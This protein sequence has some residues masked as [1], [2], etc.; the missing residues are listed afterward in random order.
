MAE[1]ES[2]ATTEPV[3]EC[4]CCFEKVNPTDQFCQK[5]GFPVKGTEEE[6]TKF[7]LKRNYQQM[8]MDAHNKKIK[9]AGTSLYVLSGIFLL[10]GLIYFFIRRTDDDAS[11]ILITY[12][13]VAVIFLLPGVWAATKPVASLFQVLYC[14]DCW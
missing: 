3:P 8:E 1:T 14:L 7:F 13:I 12:A 4:K 2:L 6:Q 11:A 10:Y 5:C 9:S